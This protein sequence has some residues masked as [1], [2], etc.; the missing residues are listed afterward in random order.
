MSTVNVLLSLDNELFR[1]FAFYAGIV[2]LKTLFMSPWTSRYRQSKKVKFT[3]MSIYLEI[4]Q[5]CVLVHVNVYIIN[6]FSF[7]Y[8]ICLFWCRLF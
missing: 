4:L 6:T 5:D 8:I 7:Q 2:L 1:T 3:C